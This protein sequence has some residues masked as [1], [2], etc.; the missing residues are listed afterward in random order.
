LAL[1]GA[2]NSNIRKGKK[3]KKRTNPP[4]ETLWTRVPDNSDEDCK[5]TRGMTATAGRHP[6]IGQSNEWR[7]YRMEHEMQYW[8]QRKNWQRKVWIKSSG[9]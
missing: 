5:R 7:L 3:Q 1:V 6:L 2:E 4:F 9:S 8:M